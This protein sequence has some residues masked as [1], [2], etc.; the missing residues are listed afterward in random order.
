MAE[1]TNLT[2]RISHLRERKGGSP[3]IHGHGGE[4]PTPPSGNRKPRAERKFATDYFMLFVY[5]LLGIAIF[6]QLGLMVWLD[7]T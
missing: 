3:I 1:L 7:L 4:A 2:D 5:G 6:A